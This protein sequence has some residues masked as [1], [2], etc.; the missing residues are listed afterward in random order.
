M[1]ADLSVVVAGRDLS[2]TE[3]RELVDEINA[4]FAS[5]AQHRAA[6]RVVAAVEQDVYFIRQGWLGPI[7]I[8]VAAHP[9]RRLAELQTA[10]PYELRLLAVLPQAGRPAE[11]RL[12]RL[13]AADRLC[14]EWFQPTPAVLASIPGGAR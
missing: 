14:G 12:H 9:R 6:R 7:K 13:H 5:M 11:Q 8:G 4:G 2:A 1:T 10:S 3:A